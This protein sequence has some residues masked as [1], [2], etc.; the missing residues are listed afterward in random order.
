[1]EARAMVAMGSA[2]NEELERLRQK[3]LRKCYEKP[4]E[5]EVES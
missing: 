2:E 5:K 4:E 1:M 3:K